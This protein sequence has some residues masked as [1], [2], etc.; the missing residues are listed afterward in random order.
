MLSE[1]LFD[2]VEAVCSLK[3]DNLLFGGIQ[4]IL[5]GDFFQLPPVK[6][7]LYMDEGK[8]CFQSENFAR[9]IVHKIILNEVIRQ[10]DIQFIKCVNEVSKGI[11]TPE[12]FNLLNSLQKPVDKPGDSSLK[13]FATNELTDSYNRNRVLSAPGTLFKY[14]AED[15]GDSKYLQRIL[16]PSTL[17]IK[18]GSPIML[19]CNLTDK[20]VN[21]LQGIVVSGSGPV[22]HFPSINTTMKLEM[23]TFSVYS[24]ILKRNIAERK[25]IPIKLAYA[26]T[27]HKSQGMTIERL[28]VDCRQM[29]A[30]GQLGVAIG[31]VKSPSGL[32]VINLCKEACIPQPDIIFDFIKVPSRETFKDISCCHVS[33][34]AFQRNQDSQVPIMPNVRFVDSDFQ[35]DEEMD[36]ILD[37][38]EESMSSNEDL[39]NNIPPEFNICQTLDSLRFKNP[40]N[41]IQEETNN[42]IDLLYRN[43]QDAK[44][45]CSAIFT[46]T[47][48][49]MKDLKINENDPKPVAADKLAKFY[50]HHKEYQSSKSYF[51][52][53]QLMFF[54][55]NRTQDEAISQQVMSHIAFNLSVTIRKFLLSEKEKFYKIGEGSKQKRVVIEE[56]YGKVRY[57]GGYCIASLRFHYR[58]NRNIHCFKTGSV[59]Q[60]KYNEAVNK[61]EILDGLSLSELSVQLTTEFPE[62]LIETASR[63]CASRGLTNISDALFKFFLSLCQKCL[64][65]LIDK[66][67]NLHAEAFF[68]HCISSI[69]NDVNMYKEFVDCVPKNPKEEFMYNDVEP[70]MSD[71][72]CKVCCIEEIYVEIVKKFL[73]VMFKQFMKDFLRCQ[74][75]EK[76][77]AHR[78]QI[79]VSKK[80]SA[81]IK[82]NFDFIM[83]D[84]SSGKSVSHSLLKSD[85]N[86]LE[87]MK[88]TELSRLCPVY[89]CKTN[90]RDSKKDLIVKLKSAIKKSDKMLFCERLS[91]EKEKVQVDDTPGPSKKLLL[92]ERV[93][94]KSSASATSCSVCQKV[95]GH[96][97]WIHC[98]I[99]DTW[100]HRNCAGLSNY[101]KWKSA[102]KNCSKFSCL[103]C[104]NI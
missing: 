4:I 103:N 8:F 49:I 51:A 12:S 77:M 78:K 60:Q 13:L 20:L 76:K 63:Q 39:R 71:L 42:A 58:K 81:G 15:E 35:E 62:S 45:F 10:T 65:L 75:V 16:A 44:E 85:T 28:D 56:S 57:V 41:A 3:N 83:Q 6:N 55:V 40:V 90:A 67:I 26:I 64:H 92:E 22:V 27:V 50:K 70:L 91:A 30:A 9:C 24:P 66:N 80:K 7:K 97:D 72:L 84:T 36:D 1:K 104:K 33:R 18:V 69:T 61:L 59:N 21:G 19:L 79:L 46:I 99:C 48:S 38:L 5:C 34:H 73:M 23:E 14:Q 68:Q 54:E 37:M 94:L 32:R 74:A 29:F 86:L 88:K 100:I 87:N 89:S 101:F 82:V 2:Q 98:V 95:D 11:I 52:L 17:W 43:L 47:S 31:R 96:K 102:S 93:D 25:Q 53:V